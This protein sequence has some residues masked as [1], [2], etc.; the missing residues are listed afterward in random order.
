MLK[1]WKPTFIEAMLFS[2]TASVISGLVIK[3]I[4]KRFEERTEFARF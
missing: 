3:K 2:I 1:H 4:T